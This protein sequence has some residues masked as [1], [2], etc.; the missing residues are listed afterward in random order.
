[1]TIRKAKTDDVA[2]IHS[3]VKV[4]AAENKMLPL[5]FGD[6]TERIRDF[7]LIEEEGE[8]FGCV[9]VHVVWEGLLEIRSLA[10]SS[11]AQGRGL[12]KMLVDAAIDDAR[13][14]GGNEV[15]TLTFVPEFFEK[16]GFNHID[17]AKTTPQG[18]ARMYKMYPLPRLWRDGPDYEVIEFP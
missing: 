16:L 4:F 15:F 5:S 12:G 3:L 18:L 11:A 10:V 1:M 8:V 13:V 9:A 2:V 6:I 7:L 14:M 17:R